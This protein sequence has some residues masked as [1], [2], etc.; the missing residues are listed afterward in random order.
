MKSTMYSIIVDEIQFYDDVDMPYDEEEYLQN[1]FDEPIELKE[2]K[3]KCQRA[4]GKSSVIQYGG[5]EMEIILFEEDFPIFQQIADEYNVVFEI[6][7]EVE[8]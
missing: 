7:D 1:N 6:N 8:I 5:G 2:F 3:R 4:F